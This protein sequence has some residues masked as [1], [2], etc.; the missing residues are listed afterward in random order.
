M[1]GYI[2][3]YLTAIE[4]VLLGNLVASVGII[5]SLYVWSYSLYV[6]AFGRLIIG[7]GIGSG[8]SVVT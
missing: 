3:K 8:A 1:S 7:L 5:I 6:F 4:I 2:A